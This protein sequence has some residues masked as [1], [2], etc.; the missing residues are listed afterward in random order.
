MAKPPGDAPAPAPGPLA[1]W[2]LSAFGLGF[3]PFASGTVASLPVAAAFLL[4]GDRCGHL[5]LAAGLL[6]LGSLA[7]VALSPRRGPDG[8]HADPSWVVSDEVAGQALAA[9]GGAGCPGDPLAVGAAFLLF[10]IF[11]VWKPGPIRALER[12]PAGW[13]VLLDDLAA[14]AAAAVGVLLLCALR[15]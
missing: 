7:T 6:L 10:R 14:G 13:G 1:R 15:A 5:A 4:V 12:L 8:G 3:A 2:T 9:L 11:D